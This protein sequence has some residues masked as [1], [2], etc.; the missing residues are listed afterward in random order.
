MRFAAKSGK[1]SHRHFSKKENLGKTKKVINPIPVGGGGFKPP[2]PCTF[3]YGGL[4]KRPE[5]RINISPTKLRK[6]VFCLKTFLIF[7]FVIE[8][9][10]VQPSLPENV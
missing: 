6:H 9:R 8:K 1:F 5:W 4:Y 2:P 3:S 7:D 10:L